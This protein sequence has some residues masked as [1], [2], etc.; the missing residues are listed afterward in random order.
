VPLPPS[1]PPLR[2]PRRER[3]VYLAAFLISA[4]LHLLVVLLYPLMVGQDG[5]AAYQPT[6]VAPPRP[7]GMEVVVIREIVGEPAAAEPEPR[8]P[9]ARPPDAPQ[10]PQAR[11]P[12][13]P[14][15]Q[16][17]VPA[18]GAVRTAPPRS[19]V[20]RLRPGAPDLRLWTIDPRL[21]Q[22]N[23]DQIIKLELLW[24][25]IDAN[26]SAAAAAAAARALSDWTYT[27]EQG[28]R[29]GF[30]D[31][32][33]Y[34]GDLVIPFPFSFGA[35]PNSDAAHRAWVDREIDRAAGAAAARASLNERIKAIRARVDEERRRLRNDSTRTPPPEP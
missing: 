17:V 33:V 23:A 34:L 15:A 13:A 30:A 24:M 11:A 1:E 28:K 31:G 12:A 35:P 16:P 32:K 2:V 8:P 21:T 26:A 5:G 20:D 22:L 18:P 25:I 3:T 10:R 27:D 19:A 4:A 9:E 14:P 6:T 7:Q 29:W